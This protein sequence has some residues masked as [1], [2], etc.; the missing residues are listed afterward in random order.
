MMAQIDPLEKVYYCALK[1]NRR[2]DDSGGTAPYQRVD[3]LLWRSQE[4]EK[5]VSSSYFRS[6]CEWLKGAS[7]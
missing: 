1:T 3:E 6:Y 2:V 4:L 7:H 5:V